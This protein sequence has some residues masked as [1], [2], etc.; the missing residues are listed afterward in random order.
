MEP[1]EH[2]AKEE[3]DDTIASGQSHW[4]GATEMEGLWMGHDHLDTWMGLVENEMVR[5]GD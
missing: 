1:R 3:Q 2:G 4:T 5:G